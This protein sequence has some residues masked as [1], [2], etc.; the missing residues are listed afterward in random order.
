MATVRYYFTIGH[1]HK[2]VCVHTSTHQRSLLFST[3]FPGIPK[4]VLTFKLGG[5]IT[6][7]EMYS[8]G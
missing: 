8:T 7:Q 4:P 2:C 3:P 5:Q 1:P 6:S